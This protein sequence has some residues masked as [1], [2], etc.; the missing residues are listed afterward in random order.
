MT[1]A[2]TL[3][4]GTAYPTRVRLWSG[5]LIWR[6]VQ[7]RGL[8]VSVANPHPPHG[9]PPGDV[10][11]GADNP[12]RSALQAI[13]KTH[14]D[15]ASLVAPLVRAGRADERAFLRLAPWA[16]RRVSDLEVRHL[17]G[18]SFIDVE[19]LFQRG[20]LGLRPGHHSCLVLRARS[21]D[22]SR[23]AG[24]VPPATVTS[25]ARGTP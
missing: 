8:S 14:H 12:T 15:P 17:V 23:S 18:P 16:T 1:S 20:R 9:I 5:E 3:G 2:R 11:V 7:R 13:L 6:S 24:A 10:R 25:C 19:P 22:P 4:G 21:V